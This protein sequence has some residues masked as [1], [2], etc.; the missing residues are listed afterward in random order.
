M[1]LKEETIHPFRIQLI[2]Q[3]GKDGNPFYIRR[4][5]EIFPNGKEVN[6]T[7]QYYFTYDQAEM[8]QQ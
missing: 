2:E 5:A 6:I 3:I 1:I 8:K 7:T 4:I